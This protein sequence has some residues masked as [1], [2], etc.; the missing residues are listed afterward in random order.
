[1]NCIAHQAPLSLGFSRQEQWS[2]LQNFLFQVIFVIQ[3]SLMAP[4]LAG[5]LPLVIPG[6]P[7]PG[8]I[9]ATFLFYS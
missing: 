2:E 5:S 8:L 4:A 9:L 1:M 7:V 3:E 6:K